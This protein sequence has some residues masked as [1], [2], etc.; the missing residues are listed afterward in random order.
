MNKKTSLTTRITTVCLSI[1]LLTLLIL[2]ISFIT[3]ARSIIQE[4]VASSSRDSIHALRDQLIARFNEWNALMRFT[5]A[6]ASSIITQEPFDAQA[7]HNL[8]IRNAAI[9]PVA[10]ALFATSNTPWWHDDGFAIFHNRSLDWSPQPDWYNW[11]RPWFLAAKANPGQVGYAEPFISALWGNLIIALGTNVYDEF[12]RDIGVIAADIELGFLQDM[13]YE[14]I[15]MAEHGIFLINRQGLFI[16]HSDPDA[17]LVNDFFTEF[18]FEHYRNSVLTS[19]SFSSMEGDTF[20]YSELIPGIDWILVSTIPTAAIFAEMNEFVLRMIL[21]GIALL[22]GATL[23][24]LIVSKGISKPIANMAYILRDISGDLTITLPETGTREAVEASRSF[25][26]AI[27][28]IRNLIVSVKQQAETLSD[29]GN[30]LSSNMKETTSAVNQIAANTQ[31]IKSKMI[32]QSASV[33]QTH[34]TMEQVLSGINTLNSHVEN[35]SSNIS[36]ASTAIEQMVANTQSVTQTLIMNSNN[37]K[38]LLEASEVGRNGLHG[39]VENIQEITRESEGLLEINSVIENIAGQTNLLSM[40]AA[41]EAAHA[42]EAGKG[43]A[44]VADEIRKLAE[45]SG[46]QSKIISDVLQKIKESIEKIT[47]STKNVLNKFEAI[48]S[49]VKTVAEQE[50]HIRC[51]MEEQGM[52][53]KQILE[54]V[55]NVN[56]ITRQVHTGSRGMLEGAQEVITE[57]TNLEKITQEITYGITEMATSTDEVNRAVNNVNELSNRTRESISSLVKVVSQFKV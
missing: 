49:G 40:N 12:G 7:M 22:F 3:N 27:S 8:L 13:L 9:Q 57:S 36:Q 31:N 56:E 53:N 38:T 51:S 30:N 18:G 50:E 54:G 4:Q 1:T 32:N 2:S 46:E 5:A 55:S 23:A 14:G 20:I 41:I 29:I 39:V 17:V 35:Q 15:T 47:N 6:G 19:Q 37:V 10:M 26:M 45:E 11:E 42:G 48:D 33:N 24:A 52:G 34:S 28:K 16:T 44:V 43:F 25:N 21:L